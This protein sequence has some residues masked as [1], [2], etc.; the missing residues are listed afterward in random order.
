MPR[1]VLYA[2]ARHG[3]ETLSAALDYGSFV[4]HFE[5]SWD[6]LARLDG[7][8]E[9]FGEDVV[10]RVRWQTPYVRHL[11]T[12]VELHEAR[13]P[14]VERRVLQPSWEDPYVAEWRAFHRAVTESAAPKASAADAREDLALAAELVRR[15]A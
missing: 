4:C 8:V 9:V 11:P 12:T 3:G 10:V 13:G 14:G 15:M 5:T 6:R 1:G 7:H 2:A